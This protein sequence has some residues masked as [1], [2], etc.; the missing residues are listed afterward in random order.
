MPLESDAA[1]TCPS[2][3]ELGYL[4]VDPS[5]GRRQTLVEDCPVCCRPNLIHASY[6]PEEDG[7]HITAT[8]EVVWGIKKLNLALALDNTGAMASCGK[9]TALKEVAHN[10]MIT[11]QG[12]DNT[13]RD[14]KLS[15]VPFATDVNV[16][17]GLLKEVGKM[18]TSLMARLNAPRASARGARAGRG[19]AH[20]AWPPGG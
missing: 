15:I 14:I 2:C 1:Y 13:P 18:L 17:F 20:A 11:L 10:L 19:A 8:G 4:A 9:K 12:A 6:A 5:G 16:A 7:F 3:F